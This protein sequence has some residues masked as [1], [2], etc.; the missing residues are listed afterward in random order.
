MS[1][2]HARKAR[3]QISL[4]SV[5]RPAQRRSRTSRIGPSGAS[6]RDRGAGRQD[7]AG[8]AQM[9]GTLLTTETLSPLTL[10]A[11][12]FSR[13]NCRP[14]LPSHERTNH[15]RANKAKRVRIPWHKPP[16]KRRRELLLPDNA[17]REHSRPIRVGN[18]S[19]A[20]RINEPR[21][22]LAQRNRRRRKGKCRRY[23][24]ARGLQRSSGQHDDLA[25]LRCAR[26]C[27]GCPRRPAPAWHRRH[28]VA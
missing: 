21:A 22:T 15:Q 27:E 23:C 24:E 25:G 2:S 16:S 20:D 17:D 26:S 3:H 28:P 6:C 1:P 19:D 4:L 9:P 8:A 18:A 14:S 11:S 12:R 13:M 5:I 10:T 7:G